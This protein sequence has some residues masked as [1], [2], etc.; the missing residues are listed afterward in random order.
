MRTLIPSTFPTKYVP[1]KGP[2]TEKLKISPAF[3]D[4]PSMSVHSIGHKHG[5]HS[6]GKG[7]GYSLAISVGEGLE[8]RLGDTVGGITPP[9]LSL[10]G[11]VLG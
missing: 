7:E 9:P 4:V 6:D 1:Y 5:G 2:L 10:G 3:I 11:A 8:T